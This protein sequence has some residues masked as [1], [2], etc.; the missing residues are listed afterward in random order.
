MKIIAFAASSSRQSI[1]KQFASWV[2]YQIPG[3]DVEVLDLND[4]ELP[5]FSEDKERELGDPA[6]GEPALAADFLAKLGSADALVVS[7]A[8]HN[9]MYSAAF[10]NLFDWCSRQAGRDIFQSKPMILLA[11]SPGARGGKSVLELASGSVPRF[12]AD[13]IASISLPSFE[14]NFS[15]DQ[16]VTLIETRSAIA[17]ATAALVERVA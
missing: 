11:T 2:A 3:A 17:A 10:K 14:E 4:Y 9:G 12:G 13:V 15:A 5:L 16:G 6:K 8:E 1:N 7:F